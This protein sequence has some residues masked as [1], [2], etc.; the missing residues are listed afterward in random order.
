ME[1]FSYSKNGLGMVQIIKVALVSYCNVSK[2]EKMN[3]SFTGAVM[4][5]LIALSIFMHICAS[6][7][8]IM[9]IK[10]SL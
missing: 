3:H 10:T 6:L 7:S 5:D 8:E 4:T 2:D 1:S 9:K